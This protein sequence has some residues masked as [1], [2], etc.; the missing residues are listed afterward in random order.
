[1]LAQVG[2]QTLSPEVMRF[3]DMVWAD[4]LT[5]RLGQPHGD[6]SFMTQFLQDLEGFR[7]DKKEKLTKLF[8]ASDKG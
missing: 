2:L 4:P 5:A 3:F 1:M 6:L 8:Q 7:A